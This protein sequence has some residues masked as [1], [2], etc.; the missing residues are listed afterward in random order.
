MELPEL[1]A[2]ISRTEGETS[3]TKSGLSVVKIDT[4]A[5]RE[6]PLLVALTVITYWLAWKPRSVAIVSVT[7]L[8][9][10]GDNVILVA[11][12]DNRRLL[13]SPSKTSS[14]V[15]AYPP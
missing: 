3:I 1:A 14:A 13:G 8:G 7:L 4:I 9:R 10:F 12:R 5:V 6:K 15:P 2:R 11:L